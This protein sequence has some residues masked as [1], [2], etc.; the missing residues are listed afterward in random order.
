M[1]KLVDNLMEMSNA[2]NAKVLQIQDIQLREKSKAR[3]KL[4]TPPGPSE[5]D[6]RAIVKKELS[7]I[8][9]DKFYKEIRKVETFEKIA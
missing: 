5:H 3:Q 4:S 2:M 8:K 6:V 9:T 7:Y 1:K